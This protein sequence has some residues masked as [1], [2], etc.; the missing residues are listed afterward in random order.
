[1]LFESLHVVV[2]FFSGCVDR[3]LQIKIFIGFLIKAQ[4]IQKICLCFIR[5]ALILHHLL[6]TYLLI[7]TKMLLNNSLLLL[8]IIKEVQHCLRRLLDRAANYQ[9][10]RLIKGRV[11]S[12]TITFS[13][14]LNHINDPLL[15]AC[16]V[17]GI[18][19]GM[20]GYVPIRYCYC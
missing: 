1:M 17:V 7:F 16:E 2:V 19:P 4:E 8:L 15:L 18:L 13:K 3:H 6:F 12:E 10:H 14:A 9:A 20:N 5:D 11:P